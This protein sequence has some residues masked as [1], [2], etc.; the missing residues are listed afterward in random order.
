MLFLQSWPRDD[1][2]DTQLTTMS[3]LQRQIR[4]QRDVILAVFFIIPDSKYKSNE[5]QK[6]SYQLY[7]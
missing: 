7:K 1:F 3:R 5:F 4:K 6:S 2:V